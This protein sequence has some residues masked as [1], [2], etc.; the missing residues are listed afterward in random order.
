MYVCDLYSKENLTVAKTDPD[1]LQI[2][3]NLGDPVFRGNYH[4]KQV[5]DDDLADIIER[6]RE[7]GC[8]K[9]MVTGSDL[10]ESEHAIQ[11]AHEYRTSSFFAIVE[12]QH[13]T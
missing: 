9:F 4:G 13:V 11:L 8:T 3:I 1:L 12:V 6:A 7:V 10:Q 2:G 5:H